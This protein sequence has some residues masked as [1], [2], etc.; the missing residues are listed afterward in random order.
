MQDLYDELSSLRE[1]II[2]AGCKDPGRIEELQVE[3]PKQGPPAPVETNFR[4]DCA[5]Q[6]EQ[7]FMDESAVIGV[8]SLRNQLRDLCDNSQELCQ[9]VLNR[10]SSFTPLV[11]SWLTESCREGTED[12]SIPPSNAEMDAQL[13]VVELTNE[14]MKTRLD[15]LT[16]AQDD[17]V[18]EFARRCASLRDEYDNYRE[19]VSKE[20]P[21]AGRKDLQEQ[22]SA[23]QEGLKAE[24]DRANQRKE[25]TRMMELQMQ[26]AQAR[27]RELEGHVANE[28][29]KSQQLHNN[30][31]SLESQ[32]KQKDQTMEQR[33]RDM[34]KAMKSSED[35]VTK[36]EKQRDGFETRL[37]FQCRAREPPNSAK[38]V[39][40]I[41]SIGLLN[42]IY[43]NI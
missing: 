31:K 36:M 40:L 20:Q 5:E 14:E 37:F 12:A 39:N 33:M 23:A 34:H 16:T 11:K 19:R 22:L 21:Y 13:A 28:E 15:E 9:R 43:L 29:A 25:R 7:I 32:L 30:V 8:S 2:A 1:R 26:K 17:F 27:I 6:R 3:W 10:S 4:Q 42:L 24:R 35:L 18:A 38:F 41:L